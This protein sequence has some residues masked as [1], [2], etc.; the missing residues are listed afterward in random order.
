MKGILANVQIRSLSMGIK[1]ADR[2]GG[3]WTEQSADTLGSNHWN[4]HLGAQWTSEGTELRMARAHLLKRDPMYTGHR[5]DL[6]L[7]TS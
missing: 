5:R 3:M 1:D 2:G 4:T 7:E 6:V